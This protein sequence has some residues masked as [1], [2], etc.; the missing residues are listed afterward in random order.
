MFLEVY[1]SL[2]NYYSIVVYGCLCFSYMFQLKEASAFEAIC[3]SGLSF[4]VLAHSLTTP[5]LMVPSLVDSADA[6]ISMYIYIYMTVVAF[7][8]ISPMH[9]RNTFHVEECLSYDTINATTTQC[10]QQQKKFMGDICIYIYIYMY[11]YMHWLVMCQAA[12]P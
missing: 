11:K 7:L 6:H 9:I 8:A 5:G 12:D 2:W 3:C 4:W 10:L 1:V